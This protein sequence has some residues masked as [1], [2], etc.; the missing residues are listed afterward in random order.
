[1]GSGSST[2]IVCALEPG[3]EITRWMSE[4]SSIVAFNT[5]AWTV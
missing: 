1:M 3:T 4:S 5:F 2:I